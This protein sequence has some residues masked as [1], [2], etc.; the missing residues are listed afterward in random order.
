MLSRSRVAELLHPK[1]RI[2]VVGEMMLDEFIWGRVSR[3]SP[4]APV[5]VVEV[6]RQTFNAGGAANVARNLREFVD[7]VHLLSLI[8]TGTD[9]HELRDLL[10]KRGIHLDAVIED[11]TYT[12]IRKTRVI[13]RNQQVVRVDREQRLHF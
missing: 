5:P 10:D 9:A 3:I 2:L 13:A 1:S 8:G 12:T 4:E 7:D 11:P 6:Q